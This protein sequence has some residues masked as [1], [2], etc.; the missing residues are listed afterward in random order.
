MEWICK[1]GIQG[2]YKARHAIVM[3]RQGCLRKLKLNLQALCAEEEAEQDKSNSAFYSLLWSSM[4][5]AYHK[6]FWHSCDG[7]DLQVCIEYTSLLQY[8]KS[9][10]QSIVEGKTVSKQWPQ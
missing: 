1:A 4:T 10:V 8:A 6:F 3:R 5:K 2:K 9:T 7:R